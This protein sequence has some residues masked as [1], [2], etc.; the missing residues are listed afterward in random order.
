MRPVEGLE[1]LIGEE[2]VGALCRGMNTSGSPFILAADA[3]MLTIIAVM[4]SRALS[5]LSGRR[6]MSTAMPRVPLRVS[7]MVSKGTLQP[8][9]KK[10]G[11][12]CA[13][14]SSLSKAPAAAI[15]FRA[16]LPASSRALKAAWTSG[17]P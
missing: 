17:R 7:P 4:A 6:Y 9:P 3:P 13:A 10:L 15:H 16:S 2:A 11:Y 5:S 12:P 1:L 8:P 14:A